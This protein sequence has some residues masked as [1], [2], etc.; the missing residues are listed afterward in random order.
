MPTPKVSVIVCGHNEEKLLSR[1]M[2]SILAQT[3]SDIEIILVDDASTDSTL[4][5]MRE[6]ES[7]DPERIIVI[8]SEKNLKLGGA[9]NLA[10]KV[11]KGEYIGFVDCDDWIENEMYE[12]LY[13]KAVETNSELCYCLRNMITEDGRTLKDDTP[14]F[15]KEGLVD[16]QSRKEMIAHYSVFV[17]RYIYRRDI[18]VKQNIY[19]PEHV[20]FEDSMIDPLYIPNVSRIATVRKPMYNYL[21]RSTSIVHKKNA[22]KYHDMIT[23][24]AAII[25]E[26]KTRGLYEKY[27]NEINFVYFRR[28]YISCMMTYLQ[29]VKK[30]KTGNIREIIT[31]MLTIDPN[32]RK[33]PYF[34]AKRSYIIKDFICRSP[35]LLR[36]LKFIY[37]RVR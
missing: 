6:Y 16:E 8:H 37:P 21:L 25:K 11:A 9:R 2:S 27:K 30:P 13:K 19:F 28:A 1:C 18:F 32:Y 24:C 26:Y 20:L 14:Y 10:L 12:E 22:E 23:V 7:K 36:L 33:N 3:L 5:I 31:A 15:F 4:K 34:K 35:L 17:Q 29:N